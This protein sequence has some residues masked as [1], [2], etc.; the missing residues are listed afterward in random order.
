MKH[1][2]VHWPR[3]TLLAL[4]LAAAAPASAQHAPSIRPAT[5]ELRPDGTVW[6]QFESGGEG[7]RVFEIETT[8]SLGPTVQWDANTAAAITEQAPGLFQVRIPASQAGGASFYRVV[9]SVEPAAALELNEA[10]SD[11]RTA[12][13]DTQRAY[14]DWIE[15]H[16]PGD[17]AVRLEGYAL[18]DDPL[19][20][21]QWVFPDR[22]LQPDAYLVVYASGLDRR[23]PDGELHTNFKLDATG[24]ALL[25]VA[26]DRSIVDRLEVPPLGADESYGRTPDE[27]G[28]WAVYVKALATPG[29]PNAATASGP[30]L[31]PPQFPAVSQ[32]LPAGAVLTLE[33]QSPTPGSSVHFTTNGGPVT[34][35]SPAYTG[36]VPLAHTA[37]VRAKAF[38]GERSSAEAFRTYFFGVAH[39]LPIV[40]LAAPA[41]NFE[42]RDGYLFG[43][44]SGVLSADDDVLQS[45]PFY[46]SN[47][48]KDREIEVALEFLEPDRV[49]RLRQRVGMSV[50]G[51]WGSRGYPQKSVAL[52]A[53]RKYGEG[54]LE[55]R[56]F[57]DRDLDRF[58]SVVLR[59][60]GNDNQS[61]HQTAPRDPITEFGETYYYG[62]YFVNGSF[63][64]LRDAMM[65]RLLEGTGLD[66]QAYRPA[67]VYVN[68]DYWGLYNIR[69]KINEHYVLANHGLS[70]RD[71][72]L[73]E[74]YG[75]AMAGDSVAYR[76][77]RT[78]IS[79]KDLQVPA[80][81]REVASRYLEIDNFI[82]YHLAVI[83]FQN[84]DIGNIKC[85][86]TRQGDGRFR[87]I[88]FDQDYGFNLWPP[89]VYLP[90][91][92]RDY[93]DYANMFEFYTAGTGTG[94]GWPN[95]G[96]RTLLLRR[97]L[98][99]DE[100]RARFIQRC[101]DLLNTQF[102]EDR[103]VG[104][105]HSMAGVIRP[106]IG[107]HLE[108]WSWAQLE[109]RGYGP[110]H[111][112]E[113]APF[114]VATWETNLV[115]LVDFAR[116][117]PTR[118][119]QDCTNH[120]NLGKGFG[121]VVAEAVPFGAGQLRLNTAT[122]AAF[123]WTGTFFRDY[124][125]TLAP[126][127]RP[128]YRFVGWTAAGVTTNAVRWDLELTEPTTTVTARFEP[129]SQTAPA[130]PPVYITEFHYHPGPQAESGDWLELFNP[131]SADLE[132]TGWIL[133]DASDAHAF[134]LPE[135]S[136][137]AGG[138]LVVSQDLIR[139]RRSHPDV[140]NCVG[141]LGFGFNN[142]GDTIRLF[143]PAGAPVLRLEYDDAPPWP[144]AADGGGPSLQLIDPR[145]FSVEPSAW[146]ASPDPGGTPGRPN[147]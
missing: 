94:T 1:I 85:W 106:E 53:R 28:A 6:F 81:Y 65:Q 60:S 121:T 24:D 5:L 74:G 141:D 92:A 146:R 2:T 125:V 145:A 83:Y 88:V 113:Y 137:P 138:Y 123:P 126:I 119:R 108:R 8:R 90:A 19:R 115:V 130:D 31:P 11:N 118:L 67:V 84:F 139:F 142:A 98:L 29:Q 13:P 21:T 64:L 104:V 147:P 9:A 107:R 10:M 135:S 26:P 127:P 17:V 124:P 3:N 99:N 52:F 61:T 128:G 102:Q 100:F 144:P 18:T 56:I 68:G 25:L 133:R 95:D 16:N 109:Q 35:Q 110:P 103:V 112:R 143:E 78:F 33:L 54:N 59:N 49:A 47:A 93:G 117:R 131:G 45:Y 73:I 51:G 72:D 40:S 32:F 91:M 136:I 129:T 36:P 79:T 122:V 14:W 134:V 71:V 44:G 69:E 105:I 46:A 38:L 48:W 41:S 39:E 66:T 80:N 57:P 12:F 62:S 30:P 22:L 55:H 58:E 140:T 116:Q 75:T 20:P 23:L 97:L 63:T 87:W 120:F 34:A 50:F 27:A 111:Q 42:F 82:D 4:A 7:A 77:M 15:I 70:E 86:R 132:T 96:G 101:A 37:M 114:T 89:D 76:A 43:M